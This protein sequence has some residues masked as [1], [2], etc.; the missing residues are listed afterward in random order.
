MKDIDAKPKSVREVLDKTKY[1]VDFFQREFRW[2]RKHIEQLI[3]DLTTRFKESY[4][5]T[6]SRKTVQTYSSYYLG[7]IIL[8]SKKDG[9]SIIDGQQRLTSI[10][11]LLIYLN[12]LQRDRQDKVTIRDLIFSEVY[13]EKSFNIQVPER[14]E[15]MKALYNG[16]GEYDAREKGESV[17]NIIERYRDIQELFPEELKDKALPYFIDWLIEKVVFVEITTISDE[18]AYTIFETMNDR[19]LNLTP[20]EMLKGYL[21]SNLSDDAQKQELDAFWRKK[22]AELRAIS[23][24]EDLEFFKA[25]LRAKY[26]ESIRLGR[27]GA[28]NEDFEKIGTRFHQWV[29]ENKEKLGLRDEQAIYNFIEREMGFFVDIYVKINKAAN[30]FDKNLESIFYMNERGLATSI[31]YPLL[32]APITLKDTPGVIRQKLSLVSSFLEMFVVFRAVNFKSYAHSSIR[33]TMYTLVKK[34]RNKN[35]D[36]LVQILKQEVE[37]IDEKLEGVKS[38]R[39]HGQNKKF[40]KFLLARMTD[41][42]E[43]KIGMSCKFEEYIGKRFQIEH[44]WADKFEDHKDE[45]EQRDEF[46]NYRNKIGDLLLL[47]EE[48]NESYGALSYEQKL[49]H[50]FGQNLLAKTLSLECYE[51]NPRFIEYKNTSGLP[52]KPHE[53][54]KKKDIDE[55]QELYQKI[56]EEIYNPDL[57]DRIVQ[58][59]QNVPKA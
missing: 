57:F 49:P 21:L 14:G 31:Y 54:F 1:V 36:E 32:M 12:N 47:P 6:D 50:Y 26:A 45:F 58:G 22:I 35:I 19:G 11:L 30:S 28:A 48:F 10:T 13:G 34:I 46:E 43:E 51:H 24:D 37:Q 56:L 20:T 2:E 41:Y 44:I 16:D 29:R 55:R 4:K 3:D 18:D 15:C 23:K 38:L 8:S 9:K 53:H 42:L 27:K 25:W 7:P 17:Q 40:I 39:M 5:E 59:A 52:F 33:Y